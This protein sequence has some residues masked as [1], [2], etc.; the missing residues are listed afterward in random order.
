MKKK[1]YITKNISRE[2]I[3]VILIFLV[4][5]LVGIIFDIIFYLYEDKSIDFFDFIINKILST[6]IL[7]SRILLLGIF[8]Y[9]MWSSFKSMH[10]ITKE[11]FGFQNKK[12]LLESG[13]DLTGIYFES[14][15]KTFIA[16]LAIVS[17]I[18]KTFS[19]INIG[20]FAQ[21]V[22]IWALIFIPTFAICVLMDNWANK[23]DFKIEEQKKQYKRNK[24][25]KVNR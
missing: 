9:S 11:A 20:L 2:S 23:M 13:I 12:Y 8:F 15:F 7:K 21:F 18:K 16:A 25:G 24:H 4:I 5:L 19:N 17:V 14:I 3:L 1:H 22:I 6:Y 10:K